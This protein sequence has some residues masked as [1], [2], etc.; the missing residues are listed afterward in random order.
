MPDRYPLKARLA[1]GV[2]PGNIQHIRAEF[3]RHNF[4]SPHL[5]AFVA[6]RLSINPGL[7]RHNRRLLRRHGLY[8]VECYL[9]WRKTGVQGVLSL[10]KDGENFHRLQSILGCVSQLQ[11]DSWFGVEESH[12]KSF[13]RSI[14]HSHQI[15]SSV[16]LARFDLVGRLASSSTRASRPLN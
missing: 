8:G 5:I 15:L 7:V 14:V 9:G 13:P 3:A 1:F 4:E 12:A 6:N 16:R 11:Q 2:L 10:Q